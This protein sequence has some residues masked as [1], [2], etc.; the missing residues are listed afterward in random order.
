V[1]AAA[2]L[3]LSVPA[4]ASAV[5]GPLRVAVE[6]EDEGRTKACPAF[7]LGF[8]DAHPVLR[9]VSRASADVVLY[10]NAQ[11]VALVDHLHLRFVGAVAAAPPV[12]EIDVDVD[13]RAADDGQ[14]A[15]L[16]PA[17]LRGVALYVA[18]KH[19]NAVE[20]TLSNLH[21]ILATESD[22]TSWDFRVTAGGNGSWADQYQNYHGNSGLAVS[23]LEEHARLS[24]GANADEGINRQ[25]PTV[26]T[27][28]NPDHT[29]STSTV[30]TNTKQWSVSGYL[31]G[32]WLANDHWSLGG[33]NRVQ[34]DDPLGQYRY[35]WSSRLAAEWDKY[36]ANDPRGNRLAVAY[37]AGYQ[38]EGYNLK[39]V[40]G[41][42][43]AKYPI[44]GL[45]ASA[46][47]RSDRTTIGLSLTATGEM[48]RP[49]RR[50]SLS[51]APSLQW[52]LGGHIDVDFSFMITQ[53]QVVPPDE[54][55]IDPKNYFA[56]ISRLQYAEPLSISSSL[57]VSIHWDRT[58]GL[59]NDR[60]TGM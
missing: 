17:F 8:I 2:V 49:T 50:Y 3:A 43:H 18:A 21:D 30:S 33:L 16:E 23:W 19:P 6:C 44:H 9:S 47:V 52:K 27:N 22:T 25:P 20:V 15:C 28:M 46:S 55:M 32:V 26:V 10:V 57:N 29:T 35:V 53:K 51:A 60:L 7:I 56:Q 34:R 45:S 4:R 13:T 31:E 12:V 59:R 36:P 24:V 54:T 5:S 41:E 39:D 48:L 42:T 37:F 11:E 38:L 40:L 1:I 14:R 58:N